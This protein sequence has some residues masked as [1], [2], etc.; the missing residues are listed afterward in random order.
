MDLL[1]V[2]LTLRLRKCCGV[3]DVDVG[4]CSKVITSGFT[5]STLKEASFRIDACA[6]DFQLL[7]KGKEVR[8]RERETKQT[9]P[10]RL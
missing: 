5:Y 7:E 6:N 1:T 3:G 9:T 8:K 10:T 4:D 2:V